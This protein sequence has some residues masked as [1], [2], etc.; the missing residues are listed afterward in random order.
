[1]PEVDVTVSDDS[2]E[3][4]SPAVVV[5]GGDNA[6][7]SDDLNIGLAL[8]ALTVTVT[9]LVSRIDEL[10][11]RVVNAQVTADTAADR[12]SSA[13]DIATSAAITAE[14][15]QHEPERVP[16]HK[17]DEPPTSKRHGWWGK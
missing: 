9:G 6:D 13:E 4:T 12:A 10:E 15:V 3:Q 8:G 2:N 7:Q 5:V 11:A 14:N 17:P 16:E 1:M